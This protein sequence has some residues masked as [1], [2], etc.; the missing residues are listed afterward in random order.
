MIGMALGLA[1][2]SAWGM[3]RFFTLTAELPPAL[4]PEYASE[5]NQ[6]SITLFQE[7]FRVAMGLC[8]AALVPVM[9]MGGRRGR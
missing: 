3:H 4:T 7:F 1:A 2:L 9:G 6:A 8:L 5:L